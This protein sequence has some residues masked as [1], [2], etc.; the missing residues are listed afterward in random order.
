[1]HR[2]SGPVRERAR[3]VSRAARGVSAS[4]GHVSADVVL[5][6]RLVEAGLVGNQQV[7]VVRVVLAVRPPAAQGPVEEPGRARAARVAGAARHQELA[8]LALGMTF[9]A[10]R[11]HAAAIGK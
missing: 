2:T 8:C 1:M 7:L 9:D 3:A 4:E 6:A 11:T 10:D 5:P